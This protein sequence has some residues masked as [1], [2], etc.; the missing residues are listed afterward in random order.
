M[1]LE[2]LSLSIRP[3]NPWE[4]MDLG[5][6]IW[7]E[8]LRDIYP[9]LFTVIF[10][11]FLLANTLLWNYMDY[12]WLLI[13]WLKPLYD[14]VILHII[15][16]RI[17]NEKIS[18]GDALRAIPG[19]FKKGLF[20][21]LT[22]L[23][24]NP[25]RSLTLPIWQLENPPGKVRR[26][27]GK[28]LRGSISGHAFGLT[29]VS[30]FAEMVLAFSLMGIVIF[31]LPEHMDLDLFN[32]DFE[33]D[34][35]W[36]GVFNNALYLISILIIEPIYV[37][38]GFS[39]YL[40]RRTELEGWDIELQFR[41][42]NTRLSHKIKS[43]SVLILII[44]ASFLSV[45][46]SNIE[47]SD[48]QQREQ[49][50]HEVMQQPEFGYTETE[51][52]WQRKT[53][54]ETQQKKQTPDWLKPVFELLDALTKVFAIVSEVVLWLM[55]GLIVLLL[56]LYRRYWL[57]A[58]TGKR[59]K[60]NEWIPPNTLFG[61]DLSKDSLPDDV[62]GEAEKLWRQGEYRA[63]LGLLYRA[64]LIHLIQEHAI[65]LHD[66]HTEGDVQ[67]LSTPKLNNDW[68]RYLQELTRSWQ[69]IAYAHRVPDNGLQLCQE[70][71]KRLREVS[72]DEAN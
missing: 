16:R 10:L 25:L 2:Q 13:W 17:F 14:H 1:Q 60:P 68:T 69:T 35:P 59:N 56:I 9:A 7:R 22:F 36:W 21:H 29:L 65:E 4:A 30:L 57:P 52:K 62:P 63:A 45:H 48:K 70:W 41:R 8:Y 42:M 72:H 28:V 20:W 61:L 39:M 43:S 40:N 26:Q 34:S 51:Q 55:A 3:R 67:R 27:R 53:Q 15:S 54:E 24:I 58:F 18:S 5:I 46:S 71:K 64:L 6:S 47:A 23:R 38:A 49:L 37:A 31:V 19:F 12:A 11:V 33:Y 44:V 66:S 32:L 50:L